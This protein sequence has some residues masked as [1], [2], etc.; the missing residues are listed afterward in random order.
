VESRPQAVRD[1]VIAG[2]H[3]TEITIFRRPDGRT[4]ITTCAQEGGFVRGSLSGLSRMRQM[5]ETPD[6]ACLTG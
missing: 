6:Q 1:I 2:A 3:D 5:A 4:I